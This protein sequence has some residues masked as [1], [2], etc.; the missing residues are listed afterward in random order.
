MS[1]FL[2][3]I[4]LAVCVFSFCSGCTAVAP[5]SPPPG[6]AFNQ[7]KAPLDINYDKTD[8]GTKTGAASASSV[9]CL[10]SFGDCSIQAAA[11]NGGV[12]TVNH[13]DYEFFSILGLYTKTTVTVYGD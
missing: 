12:S 9:L 6:I 11:M 8:L 7:Y 10:V 2:V 1:K 13:A 3:S 5:F 4:L